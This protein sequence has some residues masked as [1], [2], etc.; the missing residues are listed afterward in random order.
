M[1]DGESERWG[2]GKSEFIGRRECGGEHT[3]GKTHTLAPSLIPP[4]GHESSF[5]PHLHLFSLH[6]SPPF[7]CFLYLHT[8]FFSFS[9][10]YFTFVA[11]T[12]VLPSSLQLFI[13]ETFAARRPIK[14]GVYVHLSIHPVLSIHPSLLISSQLAC[15]M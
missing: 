5:P 13:H 14:P 6:L 2:L 1:K 8:N 7:H 3:H 4:G 9:P 10:S 12:H 15:L 11:L